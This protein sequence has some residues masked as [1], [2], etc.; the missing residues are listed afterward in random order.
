MPVFD[1]QKWTNLLQLARS[2]RIAPVYLFTGDE[3]LCR[4]RLKELSRCLHEQGYLLKELED[5]EELFHELSSGSLLGIRQLLRPDPPLSPGGQERLARMV[6]GG[7]PPGLCVAL[8]LSGPGESLKKAARDKG[9]LIHLRPPGKGR[10]RRPLFKEEALRLA[11]AWGKTLGSGALELLYQRIG[12]DL[13]ALA[14]EIEKLALAAGPRR[15]ISKDLVDELTPLIKEESLLGLAETI[16]T[17]DLRRALRI[18]HRLLE[19]SGLPALKILAALATYLRRLLQ[20]LCLLEEE[21]LDTLPS[22]PIF[23]KTIFP[24][25]KEKLPEYPDLKG[26]HPYALYLLLE[27]ARPQRLDDLIEIY[28]QLAETDMALKGG[29]SLG[30]LT[31]ENF[32]VTWARKTGGIR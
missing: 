20:A 8:F 9:A 19:G 5:E 11:S 14:T 22:Y 15:E 17:G 24:K 26:L 18:I 16:T 7:L 30:Y 1:N 23:S 21:G 31:L 4:L 3:T 13:F 10:D 25:L 2:G 32:V 29:S 28:L 12:D 27:R 6:R